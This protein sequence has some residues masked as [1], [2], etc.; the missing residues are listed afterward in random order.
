M[1]RSIKTT[2]LF[3]TI[4]LAASMLL[5]AQTHQGT[6]RGNV[7][8]PTGAV[9]PGATVTVTNDDTGQEATST[10]SSIGAFVLQGLEARDVHATDTNGWLQDPRDGGSQG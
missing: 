3:T 9:V 10:S 4:F 2:L 6:I 7:I 1:T 5:T 8:D